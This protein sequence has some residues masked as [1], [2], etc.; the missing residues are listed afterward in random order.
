M[1]RRRSWDGVESIEAGDHVRFTTPSGVKD[2][3]IIAKPLE[4]I[5]TPSSPKALRFYS[6]RIS[7]PNSDSDF[8]S[9]ERVVPEEWITHWRRKKVRRSSSARTSK[10]VDSSDRRAAGIQAVLPIQEGA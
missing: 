3:V 8:A 10:T 1:A 7:I 2:E 6:E 5:S 4:I 9:F